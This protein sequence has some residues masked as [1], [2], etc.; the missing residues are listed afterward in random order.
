MSN[1]VGFLLYSIRFL[2]RSSP[3]GE[4]CIESTTHKSGGPPE[5]KAPS[6]GDTTGDPEVN[7]GCTSSCT[8]KMVRP[9]DLHNANIKIIWAA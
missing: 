2:H 5:E 6:T 1:G 3:K 7:K 9:Y 8:S 4:D